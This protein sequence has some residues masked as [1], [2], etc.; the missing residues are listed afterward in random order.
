M[1]ALPAARV[2]TELAARDVFR[3]SQAA[4]W[5]VI[6]ASTRP[7][8]NQSTS[9]GSAVA[10]HPR[11]LLT[12]CHVVQGRDIIVLAQGTRTINASLVGQDI[13]SD[14]CILS[15]QEN[16]SAVQGIRAFTD[17]EVGE[18]VFTLAAPRALDLTLGEGIVAS[19]RRVD[20]ASIIQTNATIAPGSSGGALLDARGNLIGV[21][22]SRVRGETGLGFAV[23]ADSFWQ[24]R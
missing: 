21:I 23:A 2:M 5:V 24:R 3:Q 20:G 18:R 11:F 6:S 9:Q 7:A 15:V 12:A 13:P 22:V 8:A 14:R 17:L 16:L 19:L 1:G 4:V 10:V